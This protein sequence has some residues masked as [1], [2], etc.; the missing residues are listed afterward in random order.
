MLLDVFQVPPVFS[1]PATVS[2]VLN[3]ARP[4]LSTQQGGLVAV[5]S[6]LLSLW[7]LAA[8]LTLEDTLNQF[9]AKYPTLGIKPETTRLALACLV[10]A[11]LLTYSEV[12]SDDGGRAGSPTYTTPTDEKSAPAVQ[13]PVPPATSYELPAS[14]VQPPVP[15]AISYGLPTSPALVSAV[16]VSYN[17]LEWLPGCLN[18]LTSQ[19][20]SPIEIIL[21]DNGSP[22]RTAEWCAINFPDVRI[23]RL[24]N[25]VSLAAA[26]NTGIREAKGKFHLILNPDTVLEPTAVSK[27]VERLD[28]EPGAAAAAAK[29]KFLW[30]PS[31]LNG[32]GNLVGALSWGMD[33]GLGHLDLGQFD[34]WNE[35]PS[36]CFAGAMVAASS[37][38]AVGPL[39]EMLPMYYE[40]S[41]WCYRARLFGFQILAAPEAVIYHALGSKIP[42]EQIETLSPAKL[43]MIVFGRLHFITRLLSPF[44]WLRF[45]VS[46]L[47]E[48]FARCG[49]ALLRFQKQSIQA[50]TF[51][52]IDYLGSIPVLLKDR[53]KLQERR[54]IDDR[55]LFQLQNDI[56]LP[57]VWHGLPL[58]TWELICGVYGP[59]IRLGQAGKTP[60]WA[61][62]TSMQHFPTPGIVKRLG[63]ITRIEG[64]RAL[65]QRLG[66]MVQHFL[67]KP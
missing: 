29:L 67:R 34:R 28:N 62:Q 60:A 52:W 50:Y 40:D 58:L 24:A 27:L 26:I 45:F 13:P 46:Y 23:I 54:R 42:S 31:F 36:V 48:D 38:N 7:E 65:L 10:Q 18:S 3:L 35:I 63:I 21:I 55:D 9:P 43:K 66:K 11:G 61:T 53:K 32:L 5:D 22:D 41:E 51:A 47:A 6:V 14:P 15:P 4:L 17:S 39:D 12:E 49:L 33:C 16:I 59:M 57:L 44:F 25:S 56:P 20:Y 64:K 1:A 30:A 19:V 2:P 37:W 8:G